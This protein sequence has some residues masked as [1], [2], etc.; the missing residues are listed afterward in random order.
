MTVRKCKTHKIEIFD[1]TDNRGKYYCPKCGAISPSRTYTD[2]GS[3]SEPQGKDSVGSPSLKEIE[4]TGLSVAEVRNTFTQDCDE[5]DEWILENRA[6]K[7]YMVKYK[8]AYVCPTCGKTVN[9]INKD[10][11]CLNCGEAE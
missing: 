1:E 9:K 6:G 8:F 10:G 4:I 7:V 2:S 3:E 11:E 5:L